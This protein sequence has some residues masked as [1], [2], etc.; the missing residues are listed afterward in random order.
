M[1]PV[2]QSQGHNHIDC[3][4]FSWVPTR[5]V[6]HSSYIG[7]NQFTTL[8]LLKV[9]QNLQSIQT[10]LFTLLEVRDVD[11]K[12][13]YC[14][15]SISQFPLYIV[16]KSKAISTTERGLLKKIDLMSHWSLLQTLFEVGI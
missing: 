3:Q 10:K 9:E 12:V 1:P 7:N 14:S 8:C 6:D 4:F 11:L 5:L 15:S 16:E 13:P 2:S